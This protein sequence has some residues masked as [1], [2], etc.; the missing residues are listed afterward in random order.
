MC[1]E[2]NAAFDVFALAQQHFREVRHQLHAVITSRPGRSGCRFSYSGSR[3]PRR[4]FV[5]GFRTCSSWGSVAVLLA[6]SMAGWAM[7]CDSRN[8]TRMPGC[9]E[10]E[11][12]H[13]G[14]QRLRRLEIAGASVLR[15]ARALWRT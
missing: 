14:R 9:P 7:R 11:E 3:R 10:V 1:S 15:R 2:Y 5:T 8:L 4:F 13:Y 6:W 12:Y